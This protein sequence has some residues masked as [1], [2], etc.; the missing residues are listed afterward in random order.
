MKN[1]INDLRLHLFAAMERITD[2]EPDAD[3][4]LETQKAMAVAALAK[5]MVDS[6]KA[7]VQYMR[8][9]GMSADIGFFPED[10][11]QLN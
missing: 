2:P 4:H 5:V 1:T 9:S 8:L 7:Q 11:K 6:A 10:Q 3:M